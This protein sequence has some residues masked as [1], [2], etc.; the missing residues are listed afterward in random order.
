MVSVTCRDGAELEEVRIC[1]DKDNLSV[2][3]CGGR[4]RNACRVGK[5]R[6]PAVR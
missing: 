4:V 5:L 3:S 2:K 6:I 1:V